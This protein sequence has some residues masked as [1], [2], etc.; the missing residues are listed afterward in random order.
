MIIHNGLVHDA[1]HREPYRADILVK[2]GKIQDIGMD[3][4]S[5][6]ELVDVQGANVYPGFV[7]AHCHL[8]LDGYGIGF[9]GRDYN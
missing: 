1:I 5:D 4:P 8:G 6:E 9:E 7:E 3:L 2:A